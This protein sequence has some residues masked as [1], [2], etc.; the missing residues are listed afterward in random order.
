M[1]RGFMRSWLR[2]ILVLALVFFALPPTPVLATDFPLS[3]DDTVITDALDYLWQAQAADGNIGGF[4][5]SAWAVMTI[6]AAGEDPHDWGDPSIVDYLK[7]N[8]SNLDWDKA[9]DVERSI[10]AITAAGEDPTDFGGQDYITQLKS[11]YDGEQIGYNDTL[12]DDFWGILALI[13]AGESQ[14]SEIIVN[15]CDFIKYWQNED[16][17]WNWLAGDDSNVDDTGAAIMALIAAGESSGSDAVTMGLMFL[18]DTQNSD[19]GFPWMWGGASNS[20]SC[21]WAI[22]A[23]VAAGEEPATWEMGSGDDNPVSCLISLQ[24]ADGTFKYTASQKTSPEFMTAYAIP[25]LLGDPYPVT[26]FQGQPQQPDL[27]VSSTDVPATI[28]AG[29]TTTITATIANIGDEGITDSFVVSLSVDGTTVDTATV[30]ALDAGGSMDVSLA[31]TPA[32]AGNYTL[33]VTTDS[34]D[35][36]NESNENNNEDTSQVTVTEQTEGPDLAVTN[37]YVPASI[38][39]GVTT[40]IKARI[41]NIGDEGISGSFVVSLSI[42]G[43]TIDATTITALGARGSMDS[44]FYWAPTVA[45]NYTLRV[46]ADLAGSI[47]E[48]NE[49]N[50]ESTSQ[51]TVTEQTEGPDLA[52][53]DVYVP[54][55][56]YAGVT[57]V[58]EARISNVGDEGISSSFVV[59]LSADGTTVDTATVTA[60]D[61]GDSMDVYFDWTPTVAEDYTL[62]V[63][64]D[65]GDSVNESHETNNSFTLEATVVTTSSD[66]SQEESSPRVSPVISASVEPAEMDFSNLTPGKTSVEFE[67][68][69]TNTGDRDMLVTAELTGDAQDLYINTLRLNSWPW[70]VFKV[71]VPRQSS[72][73][74]PASVSVSQ[75]YSG[76]IMEGGILIFWATVAP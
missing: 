17:G 15:T 73:I 23:L 6:A 52:V 40:A 66:T 42:D 75:S 25:A 28:Y 9:T 33:R 48:S 43:S 34:G 47:N 30:T 55:S 20:A 24:D 57:T 54:A 45:G 67:I 12:N 70:D 10:L 41:S 58:I 59:S 8:W 72:R 44:Y 11:L 26:A 56:I 21:A 13:A 35:S 27:D 63:I 61:A 7:N 53:T 46:T 18:M 65:S 14:S 69:I 16:G 5:I 1:A 29:V 32:A 31:W 62:Q 22:G 37:V 36:I 74:I 51:I 19:G 4:A 38:Y 49:S 76:Q 39:A 68:T 2:I 50:N 3:T 71:V 60:L 64:S